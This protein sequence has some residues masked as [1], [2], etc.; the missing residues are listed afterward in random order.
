MQLQL[1]E[2]PEITVSTML[3]GEQPSVIPGLALQCIACIACKTSALFLRAC[4]HASLDDAAVS[5]KPVCVAG[6]IRDG[7]RG[8][9]AGRGQQCILQGVL[10]T[11]SHASTLRCGLRLLAA[12]VEI[13]D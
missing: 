6:Q 3:T 9:Y 12:H 7:R 1:I 4:K 2:Q 13:I 10:T 11:G 8:G 5:Y